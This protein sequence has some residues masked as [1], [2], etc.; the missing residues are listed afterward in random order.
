MFWTQKFWV[1]W[2]VSSINQ[3]TIKKETCAEKDVERWRLGDYT[4]DDFSPLDIWLTTNNIWQLTTFDYWQYLSNHNIWLLTTG[5]SQYF[6]THNIWLTRLLTTPGDHSLDVVKTTPPRAWNINF[7]S[8][9]S[10]KYSLPWKK[11]K[12]IPN[13]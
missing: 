10:Y 1:A 2:V 6:I 3:N 5:Y 8:Y 13:A 12:T 4:L 11:I 7:S 9:N